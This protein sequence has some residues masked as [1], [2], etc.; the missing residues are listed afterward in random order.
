MS[1]SS[2]EQ[3]RHGPRPKPQYTP[4]YTSATIYAYR[5]MPEWERLGVPALP[6]TRPMPPPPIRRSPTDERQAFREE[7]FAKR[8]RRV[9]VLTAAQ[10]NCCYMCGE[11]FSR[12]LPPTI[13]HVRPRASGGRSSRNILLACAPCNNRKGDRAPT[14][15]ELDRLAE[16]NAII[17]GD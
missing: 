16:I 5:R 7:Q 2:G 6:K 4:R 15:A 10:G 8:M 14:P 1:K 9:E 11:Q 17:E 13:E 12:H 3:A